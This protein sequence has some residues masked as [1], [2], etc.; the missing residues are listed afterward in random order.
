M[1]PML[2]NA[3]FER[4][5]TF[6]PDPLSFFC[7][8][9]NCQYGNVYKFNCALSHRPGYVDIIETDQ[10]DNR[11]MNRVREV[12]LPS[13]PSMP[14][15]SLKL[16]GVNLIQLDLEGFEHWALLGAQKTIEHNEPMIIVE[17]DLNLPHI[18]KVLEPMGYM[19]LQQLTKTDHVF[20]MKK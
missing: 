8:V 16:D 4:V 13:F 3:F 11:G 20:V 12:Q 1:Y 7:L 14:L 2:F 9:N 19:L 5:Y 18:K 10:P 17:A 6:E 15:D